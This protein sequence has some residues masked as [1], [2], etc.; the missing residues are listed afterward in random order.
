MKME[1]FMQQMRVRLGLVLACLGLAVSVAG[2][3]GPAATVDPADALAR[4]SRANETVETLMADIN[5]AEKLDAYVAHA[6]HEKPLAYL[7]EPARRRFLASLTFNHTGLTGFRYDDLESELTFTQAYELLR[8]VGA[9]DKA[10]VLDLAVASTKDAQLFNVVYKSGYQLQEDHKGYRCIGQY[11]CL[12]AMY[13]ICMS[14]C[15]AYIP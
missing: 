12:D 10:R 5:S 11:T 6:F 7:S 8:L 3:G 4:R 1:N 2:A 13:Y 15:G 9:Q 14:G